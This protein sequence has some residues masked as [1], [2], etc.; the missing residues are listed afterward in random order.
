MKP[1]L[2]LHTP[3]LR[4][5]EYR[6]GL[7]RQ[8][9][10]M[11]Y[12]AGQPYDAPGYDAATGCIDF[13]IGDWR[14]WR[15]VWLWREPSRYSAYLQS[16][17]TGQF[18]GEAC[19]YY[20]MEADMTGVG[21]IV[22]HRHRG[23]GVGTEGLRLLTAHAFESPDIDALFVDL[24]QGRENAI[25]MFLTAGY[26]ETLNEHGMVRLELHRAKR[27]EPHEEN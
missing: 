20:D 4:E 7:L 15:D 1:E 26:R 2:R 9:E 3:S 10:T 17:E 6:Q 16:V 27:E 18:L 23:R 21:I 13:P 12:N 24:P 25:R 19:Y 14:Y 11:S 5:M 8:P 22:E